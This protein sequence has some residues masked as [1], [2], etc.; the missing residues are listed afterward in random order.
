MRED[1]ALRDRAFETPLARRWREEKET[2]ERE[3]QAALEAEHQREIEHEAL[4]LKAELASLRFELAM[5][6]LRRKAGF[7]PQQPRM[8]AGNPDGGQ[9]AEG[10][11]GGPGEAADVQPSPEPDRTRVAQ[12]SFGTL[13]GQSRLRDG[14]MC[15]YKFSFGTIMVRGATLG[16]SLRV[17]AAAVSHGT[18]IA[19]DN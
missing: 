18:L 16:C 11:G 14:W 8:P 9:W 13:I 17:P 2:R 10:G 6:A 5:D 15:F 12:Y 3:Q 7:N 4:K 19:N 1:F